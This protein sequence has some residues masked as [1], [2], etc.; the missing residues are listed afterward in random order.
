MDAVTVAGFQLAARPRD[1]LSLWSTFTTGP[2]PLAL[3]VALWLMLLFATSAYVRSVQTGSHSQVDMMWSITP[4]VYVAWFTVA[5]VN[6]PA[7]SA[8]Q[9][10]ILAL[11]FLWSARMTYNFARKGGYSGA[12]DYRWPY[13]RRR[14]P[15]PVLWTIFNIGFICLYQHWL[16]L[17]LCWPAWQAYLHAQQP[18]NVVDGVAT[19]AF[20]LFWI[21]ET[22]ADEQQWHFQNAKHAVPA[23]QRAR[24]P[25]ADVRHGFLTRGL[26]R[27]SRHPNFFAEQ[28]MWWSL[29]LF[30]LACVWDG[31]LR[32]TQLPAL[33]TAVG[34][35][36]LS[37]LFQGSTWLT[38]K[39]SAS[40]HGEAYRAYQRRT[41]RLIPLPP[42]RSAEKA[43]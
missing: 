18:L 41:S 15:N 28:M 8:R 38:E 2:S 27:Y 21:V 6:H 37:A 24:H 35:L 31:A 14:I 13:L 39:L 30:S 11:V 23:S 20:V 7:P 12:E 32:A 42:R 36:Q 4:L 33:W 43:M 40:K 19:A 26:F 22:V 29:N 3:A 34:A 5:R 9:W 25:D 17:C 10:V 1:A 16:L